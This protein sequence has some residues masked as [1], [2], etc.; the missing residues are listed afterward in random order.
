LGF[1]GNNVQNDSASPN[2][3]SDLESSGTRLMFYDYLGKNYTEAGELIKSSRTCFV[4]MN[5]NEIPTDTIPKY[6]H[7]SCG[8]NPDVFGKINYLPLAVLR[9]LKANVEDWK[10]YESFVSDIPRTE[11]LVVEGKAFIFSE[12]DVTTKMYLIKDDMVEVLEETKEW[13][14]VRFIGKTVVDGWVKKSDTKNKM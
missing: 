11:R 9:K 7:L 12:P 1:W 4:T 13:L 14:L 8:R 2:D 5:E 3:V 6:F 10:K